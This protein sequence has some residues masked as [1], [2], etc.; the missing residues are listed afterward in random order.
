MLLI[1]ASFLI[2]NYVIKN[3]GVL[4][5]KIISGAVVFRELLS[6]LENS[7]IISGNNLIKIIKNFLTKGFKRGVEDALEEKNKV[8]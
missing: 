6:I 2:D 7:E 5:T 4:F 3:E 1:I 8:E